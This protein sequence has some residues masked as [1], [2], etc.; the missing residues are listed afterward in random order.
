MDKPENIVKVTDS[1]LWVLESKRSHRE[2]NQALAEA[3]VY[4]RKIN[5]RSQMFQV[6]FISGIAGNDL[7]TFVIRS[8]F[9]VGETFVPVLMNGV[10]VSGLL[11]PE[12]C[13]L[14]LRSGTP[15]IQNPPVN[16][17]LFIAAAEHMNEIL[18]LGAVNPHQRA[19]VM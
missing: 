3:E 11:S 6:R 18:H 5:T 19:G 13:S 14:V 17:K 1:I 9:L 4:A 16:E 2:L 7:D 8:R 12:E 10:E 15:D